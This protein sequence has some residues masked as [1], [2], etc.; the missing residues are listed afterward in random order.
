MS[1]QKK[2]EGLRKT[3]NLKIRLDD[4][5]YSVIQD[6]A[7]EAGMSMTDYIRHQ[8]IYGKIDIHTHIVA[9][10]DKLDRL[11]REF[12]SIGNNLNQLTKYFHLGGMRSQGMMDELTRC[13]NEIMKMRKEVTALGGNYRGYT[14]T[15][16]K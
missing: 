7:K 1:N 2:P 14:Q 8:A 13:I 16:P 4:I 5:Q 9:D 11:L 12:S 10:S 6:A 3:H 15:Y